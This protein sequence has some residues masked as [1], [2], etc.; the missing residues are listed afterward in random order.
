MYSTNVVR[1]E[2]PEDTANKQSQRGKSLYQ[3]IW[4]WHFYAGILFAPILIML[5]VTGGVYLFKPQIEPI[6]YKDL[7]YVHQGKQ[8]VSADQQIK[9]V[10]EIYP[11]ATILSFRPSDERKRSS[12][13]GIINQDHEMTVFVNPYTNKIVG[14]LGNEGKLM[15]V[16]KK[17]HGEI[18]VGTIGDRIVELSACWIMI[19]L[20]TGVYL[21]WPREGNAQRFG[22]LIP[23]FTKGKRIFW[24]D[25]HAVPAFWLS[26]FAAL[27]I[28][29]G[30]PWAGVWGN[31]VNK[32]ATSTQ[33][34][35][36]TGLWDSVP[37]S[38][39]PTKNVSIKVP[40][41]AENMSLPKSRTGRGIQQLTVDQVIGLAN[42]QKVHSGYSINLPHGKKGVY[43]VS[44]F[45]PL[46]KDQATLHIDQ[47]SGKVLAD[48]RYK[49]YGWM[50]KIIEVGIALHE[51]HYFGLPNQ[52]LG[53]AVC[54]GLIGVSVSGLLMWW[55]RKPQGKL[56]APSV[57]NS[58]NLMKG[59]ALIIVA[60]GLFFPL[61][62]VS[63]L[64]VLFLDW[65]VIKKV[66]FMKKYLSA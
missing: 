46:P 52:I 6:L 10:K 35:Y 14:T 24:R 2:V 12:E 41:S 15:E 60:F 34:G 9:Q 8:E 28:M 37:E 42:K 22:T 23:R 49:D 38:T 63:L 50:A 26:L 18:M 62:G 17:L 58:F 61:V 40:W 29:T 47:Y 54:L 36:P 53:A 45:P 64:I 25:L 4:R 19:L 57:S 20:V 65:F 56:G 39:A 48:L 5:A 32:L 30:L 27:L 43:T 33:S 11:R 13:V 16:M 31:N 55:K 1:K 59:V 7:Y 66:P 3:A 21:W 44:V 51:G